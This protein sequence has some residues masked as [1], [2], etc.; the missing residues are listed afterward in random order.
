M[1][2]PSDHIE[3][4]LSAASTRAP[5]ASPIWRST[6]RLARTFAAST[7]KAGD[8]TRVRSK[9]AKAPGSPARVSMT[10]S[11]ERRVG[12]ECVSPC[13][14]WWAP[15]NEKKKVYNVTKT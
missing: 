2:G 3:K 12:K 4:A 6:A 15:S 8:G 13:R 1:V 9:R 7:T 10:R 11:E 14:Y 5:D